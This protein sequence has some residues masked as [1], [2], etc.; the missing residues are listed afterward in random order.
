MRQQRAD[1]D[2]LEMVGSSETTG[3]FDT[4]RSEH[5]GAL[6]RVCFAFLVADAA[7][8]AMP[9]LFS[10][11]VTERHYSLVVAGIAGSAETGG[12]AI[13]SAL[14]L[15]LLA[16]PRAE[17][18]TVVLWGLAALL[19]AQVASACI[20]MPLPFAAARCLSGGCVG[21]IQAAGSAWIA[22]FRNSERPFALY[23]GMSFLAGALGMPFFTVCKQQVGL[24]GSYL[25]FSVLI[26]VAIYGATAYPRRQRTAPPETG[27]AVVSSSGPSLLGQAPLLASMAINFA[28]NSGVWVYLGQAG[29]RALVDATTTSLILSAGMSLALIATVVIALVGNRFGRRGPLL[30]GHIFLVA[31]VLAL[32]TGASPIAFTLAVALFHIGI[33]TVPPY[34]LA[35]LAAA[36]ARGQAAVRGVVAMNL[37]YGAGPWLLSTLMASNGFPATMVMSALAF[38]L[39]AL[40]AT[41]TRLTAIPA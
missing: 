2:A 38:G 26:V 19:L 20:W 28:F 3:A 25:A 21:V 4:L 31:G 5:K 32:I 36:D 22:Q 34:Y 37:G 29:Q 24:D 41:A 8:A 39:C 33:A 12:L 16:S 35:T 6:A 40:L 30:L 23:V 1:T 17:L 13:G 18:R 14:S 10:S 9:V 7:F 11:Y 15:R 27:A